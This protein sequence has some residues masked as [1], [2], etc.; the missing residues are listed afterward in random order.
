MLH[1]Q[2]CI[3][4]NGEIYGQ[5]QHLN[6]VFKLIPSDKT[7]GSTGY[8]N[9]DVMYIQLDGTNF[10]LYYYS[11]NNTW[12][13]IRNITFDTTI[14]ASDISYDISNTPDL[15]N[16][17]AQ[18]GIEVLDSKVEDLRDEVFGDEWVDEIF[19]RKSDWIRLNCYLGWNGNIGYSGYSDCYGFEIKSGDT[20]HFIDR[21]HSMNPMWIA[22][23][24]FKDLTGSSTYSGTMPTKVSNECDPDNIGQNARVIDH[25]QT[26]GTETK[27]VIVAI[28]HNADWYQ[29]ITSNRGTPR[30]TP[31]YI[32]NN[33]GYKID[34]WTDDE[35]IQSTT[36]TIGSI[37]PSWTDSER[38]GGRG[39]RLNVKE[40]DK[41]L[42][43][44]YSPALFGLIFTDENRVVKALYDDR[45]FDGV[46]TAPCDGYCYI[47]DVLYRDCYHYSSTHG[48]LAYMAYDA[49]KRVAKGGDW[50]NEFSPKA[51]QKLLPW[52]YNKVPV[53]SE[54]AGGVLGRTAPF[55]SGVIRNQ[56]D[57]IC[58]TT[59]KNTFVLFFFTIRDGEDNEQTFTLNNYTTNAF[60]T[61]F[62]Q[63][64][65]IDESEGL[66]GRIVIHSLNKYDVANFVMFY[67]VT[68]GINTTNKLHY[69]VEK[70]YKH[71]S[72]DFAELYALA[73][74]IING[75][76][77]VDNF[78]GVKEND[79]NL[80]KNAIDL[81]LISN[82]GYNILDYGAT[83][84]IDEDGYK[85][86]KEIYEK[87]KDNPPNGQNWNKTNSPFYN[88]DN[89][90]K[91]VYLPKIDFSH[92]KTN[93]SDYLASAF[94]GCANLVCVGDITLP[95]ECT[96]T[97]NNYL[98]STFTN[99]YSLK[100]IGNISVPMNKICGAYRMC[101]N[102][103]ALE[104][105]GKI[106]SNGM[107]SSSI[108]QNCYS[109]ERIE[110]I[111]LKKTPYFAANASPFLNCISLRF[112]LIKEFGTIAGSGTYVLSGPTSWG[113]P[114][115]KHPDARQSLVDS[116]L[117]YSYDRVNDPDELGTTD[118]TCTITISVNSYNQLTASEIDAI[119]AKGYTITHP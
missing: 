3:I 68:A 89:T 74:K 9:T 84:P 7:I 85:Y 48:H 65:W 51:I 70:Y 37:M 36:L 71:T 17:D 35:I 1:I 44:T 112:M 39:V 66:R 32:T 10:T 16:G 42:L 67:W 64:W 25:V 15:G 50:Y 11:V 40:G 4:I 109:L 110:E 104:K 118:T 115:D 55:F 99:C 24:E 28:E 46:W 5:G 59:Q 75:E 52:T 22:Y 61:V 26:F 106:T 33:I 78:Y 23:T 62:N 2:N 45:R 57:Y 117:T 19:G 86:A 58:A 21:K 31:L 12:E 93:G 96:G 20:F 80:V 34:T 29:R 14:D 30:G 82:L 81:K 87:Y 72:S 119:T 54:F 94:Y 27:M 92:F 18:N 56:A 97:Y 6:G 38:Y 41:I 114:N 105:V 69:I 116:L 79:I 98:N 113:I 53:Q 43:D 77:E 49:R 101:H 13:S 8:N 73:Q 47:Q 91:L 102:C 107:A 108:F 60:P 63:N 88:N 100:Q 103:Y 90:L 76:V 83:L 111:S 95:E